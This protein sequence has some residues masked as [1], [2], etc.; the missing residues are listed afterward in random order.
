MCCVVFVQWAVVARGRSLT[1]DLVDWRSFGTIS[2]VF[3]RLTFLVPKCFVKKF[4]SAGCR[5]VAARKEALAENSG[6]RGLSSC[7]DLGKVPIG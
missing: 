3:S 6:R 4:D 1:L 5:T 2:S 7:A